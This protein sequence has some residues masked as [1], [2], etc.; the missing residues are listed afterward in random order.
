[1]FLINVAENGITH[2]LL[3]VDIVVSCVTFEIIKQ[4]GANAP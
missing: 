4:K 3:S 2:I 1:M